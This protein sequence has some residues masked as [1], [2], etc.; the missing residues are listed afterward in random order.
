MEGEIW[1]GGIHICVDG[2]ARHERGASIT[3]ARAEQHGLWKARVI[4]AGR[5]ME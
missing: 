5:I 4:R 1:G 3:G 2:R